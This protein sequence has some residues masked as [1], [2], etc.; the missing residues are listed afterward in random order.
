MTEYGE[1]ES[2]MAIGEKYRKYLFS[3]L[4]IPKGSHEQ[5]SPGH[6]RTAP[7][8][9]ETKT[10][11][12]R[13]CAVCQQTK[14]SKQPEHSHLRSLELPERPWQHIFMDFVVKLPELQGYDSILVVVD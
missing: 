7:L 11:L 1:L 2:E 6:K 14:T 9:D 5:A 3:P 10:S 12:V 13:W 4:V 8:Y